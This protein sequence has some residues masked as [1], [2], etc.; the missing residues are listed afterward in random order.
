MYTLLSAEPVSEPVL[1]IVPNMGD[2]SE[3]QDVTLLCAVQRGTLPIFFTWYHTEKDG[4]LISQLS[5]K[6]KA[7]HIIRN[8]RGDNKGGYFC[9]GTNSANETKKSRIIMIG[10]KCHLCLTAGNSLWL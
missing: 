2:V 5:Q 9:T 6:L 10:G 7:S 1:T 8:V 4:V 3:G